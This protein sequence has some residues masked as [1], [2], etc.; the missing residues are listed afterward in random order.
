MGA[1]V[2]AARVMFG[3]GYRIYFARDGKSLVLLLAGGTKSSQAQDIRRAK[4][5]WQDYLKENRDGAT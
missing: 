5:Y 2:Q 3:S 1:G 4:R